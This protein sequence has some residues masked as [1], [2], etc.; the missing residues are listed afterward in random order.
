[1]ILPS[2]LAENLFWLG[3]YSERCEDKARLLR[4]TLSVRANAPLWPQALATCGH[5]VAMAKLG[6]AGCRCSTRPT[7]W[8]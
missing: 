7:P 6:D 5:F 2:R 8:A 4:A 3:R 1:M